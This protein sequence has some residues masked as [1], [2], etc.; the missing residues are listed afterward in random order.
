MMTLLKFFA[1]NTCHCIVCK[2]RYSEHFAPVREKGLCICADCYEEILRYK[3]PSSFEG[4]M[5]IDFLLAAYP[6]TGALRDAFAQYKFGGQRGYY[7]VFSKLLCGYL[8]NF[9]NPQDFDMIL[10][11]PL[12]VERMNE[13]G[14]NQSELL[15]RGVCEH[16]GIEFCDN[17]LFRTR[18]TQRQSELSRAARIENVRG[19]FIADKSVVGGKRILILDDICTVGLTLNECG[20]AVSEAGAKSAA[21]IALFKSHLP[22][23]YKEEYDFSK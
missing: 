6:Y 12:S 10:P 9:I 4:S 20:R 13:R 11:V 5:Y 22:H 19:A 17:A 1:K 2:N 21:G 23:E 18:H 8:E 14:F 3:S 16:F 7:V 15:A